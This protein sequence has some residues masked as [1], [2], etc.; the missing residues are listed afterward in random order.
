MAGRKALEAKEEECAEAHATIAGHKA[1]IARLQGEAASHAEEMSKLS[2]ASEEIRGVMEGQ[3]LKAAVQARTE[4]QHQ[5]DELERVHTKV[6]QRLV[7]T[8]D[9]LEEA[10]EQ[11]RVATEEERLQGVLV[12]AEGVRE[13][14]AQPGS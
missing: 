4:L 6:V 2:Q 3:E 9:E 10:L 14:E 13:G 8:E 5:L 7:G 12:A 1:T 11:L